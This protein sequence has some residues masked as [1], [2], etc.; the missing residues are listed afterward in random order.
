MRLIILAFLIIG[1]SSAFADK[2]SAAARKVT[3]AIARISAWAW[4]CVAGIGG[5]ALL[6]HQG[7]WPITNG[8]FA[9]FSGIA[10]CPLLA[11]LLKKYSGLV[12]S[13]PVQFFVALLILIAGRISVVFVLHRPF[14]PQ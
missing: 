10:I 7:P 14:W 5:L 13:V 11:F 12:V 6:I 2:M 3:I 1:C 9:L 8:W 4:F